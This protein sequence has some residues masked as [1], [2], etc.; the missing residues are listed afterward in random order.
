MRFEN[1]FESMELHFDFLTV[2]GG[3]PPQCQLGNS[4]VEIESLDSIFDTTYSMYRLLRTIYVAAVSKQSDS[5]CETDRVPVIYFTRR[6]RV[7]Q[8]RPSS[9]SRCVHAL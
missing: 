8:A 4:K 7:D 5:A 9:G 3:H 2:L 6:Y 1:S